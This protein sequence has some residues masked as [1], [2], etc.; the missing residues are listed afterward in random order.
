VQDGPGL[1]ANLD[2]HY[3]G[4]LVKELQPQGPIDLAEQLV[5]RERSMLQR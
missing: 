2:P 5:E 1:D 3:V 4:L